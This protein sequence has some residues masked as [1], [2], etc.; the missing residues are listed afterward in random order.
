MTN[1]HW[2]TNVQ[3][4]TTEDLKAT[5]NLYVINR[6][7]IVPESRKE[8]KENAV[9]CAAELERR[10]GKNEYSRSVFNAR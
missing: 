9:R 10:I 3:A 7:N 2:S 5:L 4:V 6:R 1:W 8:I